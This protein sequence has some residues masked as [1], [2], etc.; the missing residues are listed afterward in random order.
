[1]ATRID[2]TEAAILGLNPKNIKS[3]NQDIDGFFNI[4]VIEAYLLNQGIMMAAFSSCPP[5]IKANPSS[6]FGK[7][8]L[9]NLNLHWWVAINIKGLW[10]EL[11][12]LKDE[13]KLLSFSELNSLIFS[14]NAQGDVFYVK[15]IDENGSLP[16][17]D[18]WCYD[19]D[20]EK[21]KLPE[22]CYLKCFDNVKTEMLVVNACERKEDDKQILTHEKI[23]KKNDRNDKVT[24]L[25]NNTRTILMLDLK[26]MSLK[27]II[28]E[29]CEEY[30]LSSFE[31]ISPPPV[32]KLTVTNAQI[33]E[34]IDFQ[35]EP[36]TCY[37]IRNT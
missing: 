16:F 20:K 7:A 1:M 32:K 15:S 8:F 17:C 18:Q 30:K 13:P 3:E 19:I 10:V 9:F 35:L 26:N 29:L 5:S 33:S 23:I 22:R 4:Q 14:V 12:S 31:I 28:S 6:Q 37:K 11:N 36:A 21:N 25:I 27:E 2:L 34:T 24:F